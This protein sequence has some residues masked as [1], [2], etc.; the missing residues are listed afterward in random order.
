LKD[1][2]EKRLSYHPVDRAEITVRGIGV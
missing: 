1:M 2:T